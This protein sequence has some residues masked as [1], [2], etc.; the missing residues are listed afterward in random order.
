MG[1]AYPLF[2]PDFNRSI[3]VEARCLTSNAGLILLREV[4]ERLGIFDW[5]VKSRPLFPDQVAGR[6]PDE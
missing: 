6:R 4:G 3:Q 5:L 1:E 2:R